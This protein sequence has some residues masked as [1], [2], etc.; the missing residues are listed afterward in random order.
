MP[1][2]RLQERR[3][4]GITGNISITLKGVGGMNLVGININTY[5]NQQEAKKYILQHWKLS[6]GARIKEMLLRYWK[7]KKPA[8]DIVEQAKEI[9]KK[10]IN[11]I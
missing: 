8:P 1:T 10:E 3:S 11:G 4:G 9:F 5:M 7:L 2:A 6:S